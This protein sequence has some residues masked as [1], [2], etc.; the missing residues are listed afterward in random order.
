MHT[1]RLVSRQRPSG[2]E[3]I[4]FP[5]AYTNCRLIRHFKTRQYCMI[6]P[7]FTCACWRDMGAAPR[8]DCCWLRGW[9]APRGSPV[10]LTTQ[11]TCSV[12]VFHIHK[13]NE[14]TLVTISTY[15][16]Q[17]CLRSGNFVMP[18]G[19]SP[20][21]LLSSAWWRQRS[22]NAVLVGEMTHQSFKLW[23][24]R[25]QRRNW[26]DGVAWDSKSNQLFQLTNTCGK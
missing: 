11:S 26:F 8:S 3:E 10:R 5:F 16:S 22:V 20:I 17:R 14:Q 9:S 19:N 23:Q 25:N 13:S 6:T 21:S 18:S 12:C 2:M 4:R 24:A 1:L 15:L 7:L